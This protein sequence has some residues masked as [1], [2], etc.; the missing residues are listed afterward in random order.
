MPPALAVEELTRRSL[1][2]GDRLRLYRVTA[3]FDEA[4]EERADVL[5]RPIAELMERAQRAGDVRGDLP[6]EQLAM[7]WGGLVLAA[8][9]RI[10]DG[11]ALPAASSFVLTMLATPAA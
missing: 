7:A 5:D 2:L 9:P 3:V 4:S 11:L 6:P 8:L 10:A 1:E